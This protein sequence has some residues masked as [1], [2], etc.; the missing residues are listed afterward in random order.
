MEYSE[1]SKETSELRRDDGK[2]VFN[3]GNICN[4]YFTYD[5][6][7]AIAYT[8]ETELPLHV[9]KK[10]IPY[11]DDNGVRHVPTTTNGI[12]IEKFVFDVFIFSKNFAAW[13]VPREEDFS[14]LKNSDSAGQDCPSTARRDLIEL[15]RTWLL[16]AGAVSVKGE[17][18]ISPLVSYA[19]ENLQ[20][21]AQG[22]VFEG[23]KVIE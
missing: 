4:H 19:G 5:F 11:V 15:H 12:K 10:K 17:V 22:K 2:L 6:L 21:I 16:N 18:E 23:L 7:K 13:Q 3:A 20:A 8:H 1:I 9:A 14:P